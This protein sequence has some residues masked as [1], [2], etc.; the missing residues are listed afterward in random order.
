[1]HKQR[2]FLAEISVPF[3]LDFSQWERQ[4]RPSTGQID[5]ELLPFHGPALFTCAARHM[6]D[7]VGDSLHPSRLGSA[8]LAP[9]LRG[10]YC[11]EDLA[12]TKSVAISTLL[13]QPTCGKSH[14][15][16]ISVIITASLS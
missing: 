10:N 4:T 6:Y 5:T 14:H 16:H 13:L 8:M 3:D 7:W 2:V 1:M 12:Y 11:L 9:I 15:D